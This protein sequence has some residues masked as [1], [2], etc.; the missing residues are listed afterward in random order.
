MILY[1]YLHG[2]SDFMALLNGISNGISKNH[3]FGSSIH[4][5]EKMAPSGFWIERSHA[6]WFVVCLG[7][8]GWASVCHV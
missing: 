8:Y 2:H 3:T 4:P 7:L 1:K 5:Q 6:F